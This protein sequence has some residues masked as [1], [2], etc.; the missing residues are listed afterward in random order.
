MT[1]DLIIALTTLAVGV[2]LVLP[3]VAHFTL[4]RAVVT[5]LASIIG[6]GFLLLGPVLSH[7][8]GGFA[9]WVMG[10]LCVVAYMFGGVIRSNIATGEDAI[11]TGQHGTLAKRIET[12]S[13][14]ALAFAYIISVSYYLNLLGAFALSMTPFDSRFDAKLLT[15]GV[16]ILIVLI[17][18]TNGFKSLE[19]MEYFSVA[20]KLAIIAGL[21]IGLIVNFGDQAIHETLIFNPETVTGWPAITMALGLLITVQGFETSRYLG[22]V[23]DAQTRIRSMRMAQWLSTVIYVVYIVLI[24]Y[25]FR[26]DQ[27]SM[28]ETGIINM[29]QIVAPILPFLLVAAALA[30][31]LSAAIADTSGSGGLFTELSRNRISEPQAYFI[32]AVIGI[33]LT[34]AA[35]IF[36]IVNYASRGF[37]IYYGLQ[38]G[39]AAVIAIKQKSG[40]PKVIWY[41][42]LAT[43]GA[44]IAVFGQTIE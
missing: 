2:V 40:L 7:A 33:A 4:W 23:Y 29:M 27:M 8:F 44:A 12:I 3:R 32:L 24:A 36:A 43:L 26:P 1:F 37:A 35:D 6:S 22:A 16:F 15:T 18:C 28:T 11:I 20:I 14:W 38:S 9:P 25:V 39:L 31:Q 21:V 41:L 5:P 13:S 42:A 10:G 17:G 19:R 34:W 30:S